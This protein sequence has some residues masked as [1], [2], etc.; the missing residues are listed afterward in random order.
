MNLRAPDTAEPEKEPSDQAPGLLLLRLS[1]AI[2]LIASIAD[3][4]MVLN[5][6]QGDRLGD[7]WIL[8]TWWSAR[9]PEHPLAAA[10]WAFSIVEAIVGVALLLGL[11]TRLSSLAAGL[12]LLCTSVAVLF[13]PKTSLAYTIPAAAAGS[14]LLA[15]LPASA[16]SWSLDARLG[17]HEVGSGRG[18]G[19]LVRIGAMI[20]LACL[21]A[22]VLSMIANVMTS[23]R[24]M[25]VT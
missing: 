6:N 9:Y 17:F 19:R 18:A 10:I 24:A 14:F 4:F 1:L 16:G 20:G 12:L 22:L 3:R 11:L 8:M 23:I 13:E 15:L 21:A 25:H 7:F 5:P 2:A